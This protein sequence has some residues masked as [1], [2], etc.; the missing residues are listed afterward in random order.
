MTRPAPTVTVPRTDLERVRDLLMERIY[1]SPARSPA[2]NARLEVED[3]LSAAPAAP[4]AAG[5]GE[6]GVAGV[7][8]DGLWPILGGNHMD[9]EVWIEIGKVVSSALR[10]PSR[11]PEGGAVDVQGLVRPD[12]MAGR[13]WR[14]KARGTTYTS[15]GFG[16]AQCSPSGLL[17]EENVVIYQGDDGSLWARRHAE[18]SDGRF[19]E[20]PALATREEAPAEAGEVECDGCDGDRCVYVGSLCNPSAQPQAR[21]GEGQ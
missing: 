16:K 21:S 11:E 19:E 7:I 8:M 14:H 4:Q 20:L 10:A 15:L 3:M 5:V 13:R 9:A 17:D 12:A 1:G 6:R 2:H 18:F